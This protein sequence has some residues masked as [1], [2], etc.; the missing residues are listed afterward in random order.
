MESPQEKL[1]RY[2]QDAHASEVGIVTVL[3]D[4]IDEISDPQIKALFQEHL[5]VTH[6][7]ASRLER[8]LLELGSGT[9]DGKS[10]MNQL[11]GKMGDMMHAAHDTEDKTTQDLIKAF[12]TE[13]LEIGMYESLYSYSEG[14][15]DRETAQLARQIQSE[16]KEAADKIFPLI[17][18]VAK[19]PLAK[20]AQL[21]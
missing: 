15:G 6:S 12:A 17:S 1:I 14:L 20:A 2:L 4:F 10:F 9:S 16:E 3:K 5:Q 18:I 13:N 19:T 11:I 21:V 7:Q 8:R